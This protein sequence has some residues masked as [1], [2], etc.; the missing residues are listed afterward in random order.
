MTVTVLPGKT[1]DFGAILD[2]SQTLFDS[3]PLLPSVFSPRFASQNV[4]FLT[5]LEHYTDANVLLC[6][7]RRG[8]CL[9][10]VFFLGG[11]KPSPK[12]GKGR[13]V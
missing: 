8:C 10:F 13:L 5:I 12:K 11:Q 9:I 4:L 7:T 1:F 6:D 2:S 3:L